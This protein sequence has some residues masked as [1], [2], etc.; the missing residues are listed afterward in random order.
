[1]E[2][3]LTVIVPYRP[4]LESISALAPIWGTPLAS[5]RRPMGL[6]KRSG[7]ALPLSASSKWRSITPALSSPLRPSVSEEHQPIGSHG[8]PT[9][10]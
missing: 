7:P 3:L 8:N 10:R 4:A 9:S 5:I 6:T 1:M 2:L